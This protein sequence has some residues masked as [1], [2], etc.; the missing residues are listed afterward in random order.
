MRRPIKAVV[1]GAGLTIAG[2]ANAIAAK[3]GQRAQWIHH[4][5]LVRCISPSVGWWQAVSCARRFTPLPRAPARGVLQSEIWPA[6]RSCRELDGRLRKIFQ[7]LG[8]VAK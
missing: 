1:F 5:E 4:H 6:R 2:A 8:M 3:C 7:P